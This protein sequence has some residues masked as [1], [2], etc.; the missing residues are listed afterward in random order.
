[1]HITRITENNRG[2]FDNLCPEDM[3]EDDGLIFLG[4]ISDEGEAS[5]LLAVSIS[6]NMAHIEWLYTAPDMR[7]RRAATELVEVLAEIAEDNDLEGV[8]ISFEDEDDG[9]EEFLIETGFLTG[10]STDIYEIPVSDI[11]NSPETER[12]VETRDEL[13][14][15]G[16][17]LGTVLLE[18]ARVML[19]TA[20]YLENGGADVDL[21]DIT[22]DISVALTDDRGDIRA[23]IIMRDS[24]ED[25]DIEYVLCD[26]SEENAAYVTG[27][28]YD[29]LTD[30]VNEWE[31][32]R[33]TENGG[34]A[35]SLMEALTGMDMD[36]YRVNSVMY[37]VRLF[38]LD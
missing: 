24:D 25:A 34:Q 12:A 20:G 33:V 28:L 23:C 4:A 6:G 16:L 29:I 38:E 31:N 17:K 37:G 15:K 18:D 3:L 10:E 1:M 8:D 2:Y 35:V 11:I 21:T 30:P 26:P 14:K 22:P 13:A 32:I 19:R 9:M 5:A 27:A 7:R 36:E